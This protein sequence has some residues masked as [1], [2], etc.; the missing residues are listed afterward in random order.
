MRNAVRNADRTLNTNIVGPGVHVG[1]LCFIF[2]RADGLN[3]KVHL[4][5]QSHTLEYDTS[6]SCKPKQ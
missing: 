1:Q 3:N 4:N 6:L 2:Y 5:I